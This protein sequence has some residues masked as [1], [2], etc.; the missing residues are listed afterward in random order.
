MQKGAR[1]IILKDGKILLGKRLKKDSFY[2]LWCTFGGM[3]E[4][5]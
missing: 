4:K 5:G 2:R 1:A 3:V